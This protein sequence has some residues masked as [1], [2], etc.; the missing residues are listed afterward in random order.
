MYQNGPIA[1]FQ[2]HFINKEL[3]SE[4]VEH[5]EILFGRMLVAVEGQ[6]LDGGT[7]FNS[8]IRVPILRP[9]PKRVH[10]NT[11]LLSTQTVSFFSLFRP[12]SP[13]I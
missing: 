2:C 1:L 12:N 5:G 13:L 10:Y 7:S 8:S 11:V 4:H 6:C 9:Q 3:S